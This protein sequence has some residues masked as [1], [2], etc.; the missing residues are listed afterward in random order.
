MEKKDVIAY[1]DRCAPSWD[2]EMVKSDEI[3]GRILDN[4]EVMEGL[5]ILDVACGTGVMIPY[6]LER[7]AAS[8]TAIDI[9]PEMA[10]IAAEKFGGEPRV[11][12][13][14]GDVEEAVFD[15]QFDRIV[16]Y[17]A[18][19][20]F[21]NPQRLIRALA[22]FL[23]E[24]GRLTIAHGAS[25]EAIDSHHSGSASKVSNGLM[26][27]DK[28]KRLFDPYFQVEVMISNS[29]MYQ[30]SGV[31]WETMTHTHDGHTHSHTHGHDHEHE[32]EHSHGDAAPMDELLALMKYMVGHNDAHAQELSELAD[33]L[34]GAG[35]DRAYQ[36]IMDIVT[37]FDMVNA[38]LDAIW[39]ELTVDTL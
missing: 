11:R 12:V 15:R 36:Q 6:Y 29:R 23:K 17:N 27:A 14:C 10:K 1:F 20:H 21:P 30:V 37:D 32:Y 28:L 26:Q 38:R 39:K 4:A 5:D 7:N 34:Q 22:G 33:Q 19:P 9:S 3:I 24:G 8:V 31:K 13:I 2:A 16:V 18:F 35:K 25:R